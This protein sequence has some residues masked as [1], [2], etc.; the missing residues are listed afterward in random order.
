MYSIQGYRNDAEIFSVKYEVKNG[1]VITN[2]IN[3][4]YYN[5]SALHGAE[6]K[7]KCDFEV[8][9]NKSYPS[10]GVLN[11]YKPLELKV[12]LEYEKSGT[13]F[14][15]AVNFGE[16]SCSLQIT[17][18]IDYSSKSLSDELKANIDYSSRNSDSA[19]YGIGNIGV[20]RL[21]VGVEEMRF[22]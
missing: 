8:E 15:E 13:G 10:T 19:I 6:F 11:E 4:M 22:F 14:T 9:R 20:L 17:P 5:V 18:P 7:F 12:N 3:H 2:N 1:K 21:N 16:K